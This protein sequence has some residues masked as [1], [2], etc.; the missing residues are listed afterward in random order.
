MQLKIV[1]LEDNSERRAEMQACIQSR[2]HQ[3]E[4]KFFATSHSMIG[5]LR[6]HLDD[7]LCI[8]LDH[9]LEPEVDESG[10]MVDA[11]IGRDVADYLA[12]QAPV[13][14]VVIH[15]TNV[16]A[17]AGMEMVLQES[18][19]KTYKVL[20]HDDLEWIATD[21]FRAMR[22]AIVRSVKQ[23]AQSALQSARHVNRN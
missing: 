12:Q 2:F 8:A 20:P 5:Y 4:I 3:Y 10:A 23:P 21:W 22:Q 13:C 18:N 11:G 15:T 6:D 19:W 17:A 7:A 1:I 9:D 14:P 16:P